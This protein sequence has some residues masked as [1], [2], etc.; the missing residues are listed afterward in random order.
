MEQYLKD[1]YNVREISYL[2]SEEY[3]VSYFMED[4]HDYFDCGQGYY[5]EEVEVIVKIKDKFYSVKITAEIG[6]SK[7][8][9]GDRL[10]FVEGAESV[11]YKQ[12][13][14]PVDKNADK[15]KY[16]LFE[17]NFD[18]GESEV[19][20]LCSIESIKDLFCCD[21]EALGFLLENGSY[22]GEWH[23]YHL[24]YLADFK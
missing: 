17:S 12:I 14:K 3:I 22:Y 9:R 1:Q 5:E 19:Y 4:P 24:I 6:S 10:Y 18:E 7:Q 23:E 11:E 21:D 15:I 8:D 13:E 16:L 2:E 20:K